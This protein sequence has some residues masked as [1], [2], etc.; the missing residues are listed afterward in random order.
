MGRSEVLPALGWVTYSIARFH[1]I[2]RSRLS[3]GRAAPSGKPPVMM[4]IVTLLLFGA[5]L[6]ACSG[7]NR[8]EDIVP[9]WANTSPR[10][11]ATQYAAPKNHLEG[12][13]TPEAE[14]RSTPEAEPQEA[15]KARVQSPS[16][17]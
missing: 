8:V 4:R 14:P 5:L 1:E 10:R 6:A 9:G 16:E 11:P 13:G 2:V 12:R 7:S 15:K 17:E 3:S